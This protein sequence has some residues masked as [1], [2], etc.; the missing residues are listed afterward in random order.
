MNFKLKQ[1]TLG[2]ND[3]DSFSDLLWM[4]R[5]NLELGNFDESLKNYNDAVK[6]AH[7]DL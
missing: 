1:E 2:K 5:M 4:L 6:Y 7:N 3:N